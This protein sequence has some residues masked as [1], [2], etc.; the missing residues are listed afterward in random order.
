MTHEFGE[1][2]MGECA[3][4]ISGMLEEEDGALVDA[5]LVFI[6]LERE[7]ALRSDDPTPLPHATMAARLAERLESDGIQGVPDVISPELIVG[8]LS[9]ED[10]FLALAGRPRTVP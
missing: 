7:W 4:W 2:L 1:A 3:D 6:I 8:V 10:E 5:G 9:W